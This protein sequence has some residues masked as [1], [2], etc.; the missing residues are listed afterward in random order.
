MAKPKLE[1]HLYRGYP[2]LLTQLR[3]LVRLSAQD[4]N[5]GA[6][7]LYG[8]LARLTPHESSD[9]D[10]LVLCQE[11]QAFIDAEEASGRGMYM[12]VEV[13]HPAEVW[14]LAPQ[15]TDMQASDLSPVLLANIAHDGV[16]LYQRGGATLPPALAKLV[17]QERWMERVQ[18]LLSASLTVS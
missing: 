17:P 8:S 5:I 4:A 1:P 7:I 12:I 2:L 16:L 3:H 11:P 14:S 15:V 10:L 18:R 13:T 9:V 6:L